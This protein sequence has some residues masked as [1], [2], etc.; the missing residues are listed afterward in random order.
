MSKDVEKSGKLGAIIRELNTRHD[1]FVK[2]VA[3]DIHERARK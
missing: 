3:E 2:A 1:A